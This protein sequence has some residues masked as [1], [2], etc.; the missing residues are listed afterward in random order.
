MRAS[1]IPDQV[2]RVLRGVLMNKLPLNHSD[3]SPVPAI[4][5]SLVAGAALA[6][7][8]V[9]GLASDGSE[10]VVTGS[11]MLA[12][13]LGWGL[14]AYLSTRYSAQPQTWTK[15]PALF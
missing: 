12:F 11:V 6:I 1:D 9:L 7:A 13:G 14:M 3:R 5:V 15:V 2:H 4:L 10:P 8:L